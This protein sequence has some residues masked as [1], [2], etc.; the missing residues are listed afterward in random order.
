MVKL[1]MLPALGEAYHE[2]WC[3][4]VLSVRGRTLVEAGRHKAI[5]LIEQYSDIFPA[6]ASNNKGTFISL[7]CPNVDEL[8]RKGGFLV[9]MSSELVEDD[10]LLIPGNFPESQFTIKIS[11]KLSCYRRKEAILIAIGL[12]LLYDRTS[13]RPL[14]SW[15]VNEDLS[16]YKL[17]PKD[18]RDMCNNFACTLMP[19]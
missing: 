14:P 5:Y 7:G 10:I 11:D 16:N 8:C 12:S 4:L 1:S 19:K 2:R 6:I 18:V 15:V 13:I 9:E 17:V 3:S